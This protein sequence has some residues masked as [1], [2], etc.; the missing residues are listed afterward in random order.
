M[1]DPGYLFNHHR[2]SVR[3]PGLLGA[4]IRAGSTGSSPAAGVGDGILIYPDK[5]FFAVGD[6]SDR[7]PRAVR[8]IME[9]F[10]TI[11]DGLPDLRADRVLR[12]DE[13]AILRERVLLA[14]AML[15]RDLYPSDGCTFTGVLLFRMERGLRG[16]LFHAG[17]SLL[18]RIDM[19]NGTVRRLTENNFWFVGRADRFSQVEEISLDASSRLVFATD[20]FATLLPSGEDDAGELGEVCRRHPVEE[21]PDILFER[22][23]RP[24]Q[25]LDDAAVLCLSPSGGTGDGP[26]FILG[27][28]SAAE[29]QRRTRDFEGHPPGDGY[30]IHVPGTGDGH[31]AI[32]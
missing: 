9:G 18:Y 3:R 1:Q 2:R 5:G 20:G 16:L 25:V 28:T 8:R 27:G 14:A 23:D 12:E 21:L 32:Y 31:P 15:I 26:P 7:N 17:D 22:Y 13:A 4:R 19:E 24:G 10:N 6:G 11:L 29:E 30:T